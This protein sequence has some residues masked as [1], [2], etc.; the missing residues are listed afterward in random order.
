MASSD[1]TGNCGCCDGMSVETPRKVYN[2]AGLS[3]ISYRIGK[4]YDF[5]KSLLAKLT[6]SRF[7]A[8][9]TLTSR[10]DDDFTVALIDAFSTVADVLTFYQERIANESYLKTA[11]ELMS[12]QEQAY[13]IGYHPRP[14]V[15]ASTF[16]AFTLDN[17]TILPGKEAERGMRSAENDFPNITIPAGT[18]V[19]SVPEQDE[20]PQYF[21]TIEDITAKADWNAMPVRTS[22]EQ[23]SIATKNTIY[24]EGTDYNLKPGDQLLLYDNDVPYFKKI[25]H[26]LVNTDREITEIKFQEP[27]LIEGA[28][29]MVPMVI[30][31]Q[32]NTG[33]NYLIGMNIGSAVQNIVYQGTNLTQKE[34]NIAMSGLR[35]SQPPGT[36]VVVFREM[37][38]LFGYNATPRMRYLDDNATEDPEDDI[39][40]E[41]NWAI[42]TDDENKTYIHLDR[43]YEGI[44]AG[45]N[46][47]VG[48]KIGTGNIKSFKIQS[49]DNVSVSRY[50]ISGKSTRITLDEISGVVDFEDLRE[51]IVYVKS[52]P[53]PLSEVPLD[54]PIETGITEI[55]LKAYYHDLKPGRK[56]IISGEL[57]DLPGVVR[58]EAHE[59]ASV[60]KKQGFIY[61]TIALKN[62]LQNNFIRNSV[63]INAN[64]ALATHGE[65]VQEVLG[66]GAASA[67]FQKFK[68]KQP[69]LTYISSDDPT[70]TSS[71]LEIRVNDILWQEVNSF[72]GHGSDET[73]YTVRQ[74]SQGES[75]VTFGDG[76]TG[77][78]LPTG[79]QNVRAIYR[80]GIGAAGMLK[81]NQLSQLVSR[82]L[83]LKAVNNP[84]EPSGA[85]DPELASD[86]RKNANLTIFT[87][88][89]IVS[90]QDFE[91]YARAFAGISKA[92][93]VWVWENTKKAVHIT[94][95]GD[96]GGEVPESSL[97]Y[98]N[99][100]E[101]IE[102]NLSQKTSFTIE[103]Y[104]PKYFT[105]TGSLQ[106]DPRYE[107]DKVHEEII[108]S[109]REQYSFENREF[110]QSVALSELIGFIHRID[111]VIAVDIDTLYIIT[112]DTS[113]P[114][115]ADQPAKL[116]V[117]RLAEKGAEHA[118]PAE[119]LLITDEPIQ[120]KKM[121]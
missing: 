3:A 78:R 25:D 88:G 64:V 29:V 38:N 79:N 113:A 106:V 68:L 19:Q 54:S 30:Y 98:T 42:H 36:R 114:I 99:L 12:S 94:I 21:E 61:S 45:E 15:A 73:I 27:M 24:V 110:G 16:L 120:L 59:L 101:S 77:S 83:H 46:G 108:K 26:A 2:R 52:E 66:S 107:F 1:L 62:S 116:L 70:G 72:Y 115:P 5:K 118:N 92:K 96:D 84:V 51:T 48:I 7:E 109:I 67:S 28:M 112:A 97:L 71:S 55:D 31:P 53:L 121:T 17:R 117:A 74:N 111:G 80:K 41:T 81:A 90:L 6:L 103:N 119:L 40:R 86:I 60:S 44:T 37:A 93:S 57:S 82:P 43:V 14:G 35:K 39:I 104:L 49:V 18:K 75:F 87:L 56:V 89:R 85:Q 8:L 50:D 13:L 65:T 47:Y 10:S 95:A 34:A 9:Q 63:R 105:F 91:D 11:R 4:H 76:T 100:K 22:T 69:P 102:N 58:S 32:F 20:M 33:L 23:T